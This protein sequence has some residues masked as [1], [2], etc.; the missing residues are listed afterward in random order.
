MKLTLYFLPKFDRSSF[1]VETSGPLSL[2]R[3]CFYNNVV[4]VSPVASYGLEL[5]TSDNFGTNSQ[6]RTCQFLSSFETSAQ[7][8]SFSPRCINFESVSECTA[9]YT[10]SPTSAPSNVPSV[11]PSVVASNAP[12]RVPSVSPSMSPTKVGD[13]YSPSTE[14]APSKSPS[15]AP[16]SPFASSNPSSALKRTQNP[17]TSDSHDISVSVLTSMLIAALAM[18]AL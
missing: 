16:S 9:S 18:L 2:S 5:Q 10:V 13:T 15:A 6:G 3:N 17:V 11:S 12:S 14:F 7:F 4:G 1:L 8:V